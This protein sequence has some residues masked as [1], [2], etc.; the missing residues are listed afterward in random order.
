MRVH[1]TLFDLYARSAFCKLLR[2]SLSSD[3]SQTT[4]RRGWTASHSLMACLAQHVPALP[5]VMMAIK[6]RYSEVSEGVSRDP[7][8]D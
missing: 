5:H 3:A 6:L 2:A 8:R 7:T 4:Q 1:K